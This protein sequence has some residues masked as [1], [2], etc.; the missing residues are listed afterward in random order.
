MRDAMRSAEA[1]SDECWSDIQPRLRECSISKHGYFAAEGDNPTDLAFIC[2]GVYRAFYR[3]PEGVEYNKTFF[4]EG[5]FMVALTAMVTGQPNLINLQALEDSKL[6]LLDYA[7][8]LALYDRWPLLERMARRIIEF[9]W[10]KKEIREIRLV[11]DDATT[12]Y[13]VFREEH[14][15]L[16]QRIPQYHIASYLGVTPIQLSRIRKKLFQS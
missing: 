3:T 8:L 16:E 4:P 11:T 5:T 14:P 10:A 1:I 6:L 7:Q 12:R 9:E 2:K 15:G 13:E